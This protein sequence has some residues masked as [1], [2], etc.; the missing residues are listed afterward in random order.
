[1]KKYYLVIAALFICLFGNVNAQTWQWVTKAGG[2][3]NDYCNGIAVDN[4]GNS[5]ITGT[6]YDSA[7]FGSTTL[8]N[9]GALSVYIAK[10]DIN[11]SFVWAKLAAN[12][13]AISVSGI[14]LDLVG[15]ISIVGQYSGTGTFGTSIPITHISS[16][17]Y[18]VYVARYNSTGDIIWAE[19]LGGTGIDYAGGISRDNNGS[20]FLTGD[21]HIS[22]F[23]YSSSKIF[24]AK[25]DSMGNNSWL[26]TEV[27]NGNSHFGNSI[28]TD[29]GGNSYITGDFFN[30]IKFTTSDS[31][32][33]G[34][35]ESN[36]FIA[37]FDA[38]GNFLWGQKAGG[39]SGYCVSKAIDIDAAG[40]SYITGSYHGTI[41]FG[42]LNI[43]GTSGLGYDVC[44][45]KCDT[46]GNFVWVNKSIGKGNSS[47][48][49]LDNFGNVF[50]SGNFVQPIQ[51][52][53]SSLTSAGNSDIFITELNP[54]GNFIWA[55]SCGGLQN[56]FISRATKATSN[57]FYLAGY[58]VDTIYFGTSFSLPNNNNV[59]SDIFIAKLNTPTGIEEQIKNDNVVIYPNPTSGLFTISLPID[60]AE[61]RVMNVHGQQILKAQTTEK[62]THLQLNNN[63]VYFVYVKTRQG[64]ITRKLIV[65]R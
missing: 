32:E 27:N 47:N 22:S 56:D 31:I 37:K 55:T 40:N 14:C 16:G 9:I 43:T 21:F 52:G 30:T 61:I 19:S 60:N 53:L 5:Y 6:F 45:A 36:I 50:V 2:I 34:N 29:S 44:I 48:I 8:V 26:K 28:K 13:S 15:N 59:K 12:G 62:T 41:S 63:G 42:S 23:P 7:S 25:Y 33:A 65:N 54:S 51:F 39:G 18:D 17:S 58:F 4:M 49:S 35:I 46:G 3:E 38:S 1:M 24:I 57:G 64:T 11:G 20:L 10:Y